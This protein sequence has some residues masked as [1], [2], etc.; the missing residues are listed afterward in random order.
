MSE[1]VSKNL[2]GCALRTSKSD[3][4]PRFKTSNVLVTE[5]GMPKLLD[6]GIAKLI[7]EANE[8]THPN[9]VTACDDTGIRFARTDSR[10]TDHDCFRCLFSSGVILYELLTGERPYKIKS[11]SADEISKIITDS[12]PLKPSSVLSSKN[13]IQN[14]ISDS[15]NPKSKIQNPKFLKGRFG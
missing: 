11:K 14:T 15:E 12:E 7:D 4:S 3:H 10:K 2:F 6:F 9:T 13:K 1:F 8:E 5:D